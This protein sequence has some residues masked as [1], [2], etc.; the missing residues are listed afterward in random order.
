M[1]LVP[2]AKRPVIIDCDP[3]NDDAFALMLAFASPELRVL[4]VTVVGGNVGLERTLANALSLVALARSS[5]PVFAGADRPLLGAFRAEP[6]IQGDDGLGGVRLPRGGDPQPQHAVD[7][8]RQ[9]LRETPEPV[10]LIGIG[11]ATNLALALA[12]E[13]ALADRIA[14]IVLMAGAWGEGNITPAAEFNAHNDPEA[15]QIVLACGRPIVLA[16]LEVTAQALATPDRLRSL[17]GAGSGRCLHAVC[18]IQASIRPSPRLGGIGA[19]LHDPCAV[20]WLIRPELFTSRDCPA[21]VDLAPGADRGRTII[22][23]WG[24][25]NLPPNVTVLESL[26]GCGFFELLGERLAGL[27]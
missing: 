11:P 6:N 7:A 20:A 3:G 8:I 12:T 17:R 15:L 16:T 27:P 5:A 18:D 4:A 14:Q 26:D 2:T 13:P 24:R 9:I 23:R 25:T 1:S 21:A 10:T 19:P 22:D